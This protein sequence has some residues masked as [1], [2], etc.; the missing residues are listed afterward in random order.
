MREPIVL[1][2]GFLS[3]PGDYVPW[4][5]QLEKPPYSRPTFIVNIGRLRWAV[6]RDDNFTPQIKALDET[7]TR[8]RRL[9]GADKVWVI[10]HSAGGRV[11]RLWM[12][13]RP[14]G[15]LKCGGHPQVRG[16]ISLGVPY[17][18]KEP[19]AI[20]SAAFVNKYYPGAYYPDVTYVCAIGR[21]VFGKANGSVDQRFAHQSYRLQIPEKPEQ[22]GD[23]VI[24]LDGALMPGVENH[25]INGVYH[26]SVLG[27]PGYADPRALK[28]WAEVL[29]GE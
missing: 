12:G 19:W 6:T 27:R 13:D 14:Y 7:V 25:V 3:D 17:T 18:T 23:G 24:P 29:K 1:V 9:T 4:K 16:L 20:K 11:A 8:A 5:E 28:V 10:G 21:S 26:V 15:G 22:W 2:G